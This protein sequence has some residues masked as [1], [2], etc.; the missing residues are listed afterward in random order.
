DGGARMMQSDSPEAW[1]AL[2][3]A[4]YIQRDNR[5]TIDACRNNAATSRQRVR[6]TVNIR[7]DGEERN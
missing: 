1:N 4:A 3:Q 2:V 7:P 6:C 5:D